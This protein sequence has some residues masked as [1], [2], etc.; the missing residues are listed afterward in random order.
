MNL[1]INILRSGEF[2]YRLAF[3]RNYDNYSFLAPGKTVIFIVP[4]NGWKD[5]S[6]K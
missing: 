6:L 3:R 5:E 2:T 1:N 4:S